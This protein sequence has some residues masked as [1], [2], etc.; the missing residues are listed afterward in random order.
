MFE[1]AILRAQER[2]LPAKLVQVP[3][4]TVA[5]EGIAQPS[6]LNFFLV[7]QLGRAPSTVVGGNVVLCYPEVMPE[8][9][10]FEI[11]LCHV[12]RSYYIQQHKHMQLRYSRHVSA[13]PLPHPAP[14][15]AS[16]EERNHCG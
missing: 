16:R 14:G 12:E 2:Y 4:G 5:S 13:L 8:L 10:L 6:H 1:Q 7:S 3:P 11:V 9:S 15:Q